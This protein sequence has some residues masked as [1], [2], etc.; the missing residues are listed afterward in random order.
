LTLEASGQ[1]RLLPRPD[2]RAVISGLP[3]SAPQIG[4]GEGRIRH[5]QAGIGHE[6]R[7]KWP[8]DRANTKDQL[9]GSRLRQQQPEPFIG[10]QDR[11]GIPTLIQRQGMKR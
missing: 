7:G 5:Q 10:V 1:Q 11:D 6:A 4:G 9:I 2:Y 3:E 8:H